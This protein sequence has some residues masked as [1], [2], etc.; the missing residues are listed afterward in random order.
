MIDAVTGEKTIV[1][2]RLVTG[3][4]QNG[5]QNKLRLSCILLA[6]CCELYSRF[7]SLQALKHPF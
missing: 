3:F 5:E 6:N 2:R 1:G 7:F 4:V